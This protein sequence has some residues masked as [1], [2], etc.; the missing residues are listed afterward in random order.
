MCTLDHVGKISN[1]TSKGCEFYVENSKKNANISKE[2][3][4]HDQ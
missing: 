2:P 4:P 1:T 3:S